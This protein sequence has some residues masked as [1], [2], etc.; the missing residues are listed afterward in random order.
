MLPPPPAASVSRVGAGAV[1]SGAAMEGEELP[2]Q[3][4]ARTIGSTQEVISCLPLLGR[5]SQGSK[6]FLLHIRLLS[7]LH[8]ASILPFAPIPTFDYRITMRR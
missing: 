8:T 4:N 7:I 6:C 1:W 3:G 2:A 5:T